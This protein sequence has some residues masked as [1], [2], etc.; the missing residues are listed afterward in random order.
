MWWEHKGQRPPTIS[1][2]VR[3]LIGQAGRSMVLVLISL[4]IGMAGYSSFEHLA[5]REK[6]SAQITSFFDFTTGKYLAASTAAA[7]PPKAAATP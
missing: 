7:T 6:A 2:F 1:Q 5:W 4:V 3:R